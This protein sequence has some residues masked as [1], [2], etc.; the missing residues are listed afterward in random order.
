MPALIM[1]V[2]LSGSGKSERAQ[3]LKNDYKDFDAEIFSLDKLIKTTKADHDLQKNPQKAIRILHK[4]I[5]DHLISGK[6]AIYIVKNFKKGQRIEFL[7]YISKVPG[8]IKVCDI[9]ATPYEECLRRNT[10][11]KQKVPDGVIEAEY[12]KWAPPHYSEGFD[13]INI[14]FP[15]NF[16]YYTIDNFLNEADN[17]DQNNSNHSL[18]LGNHCKKTAKYILAQTED[19]ILFYSALLHDNGKMFVKSELNGKGEDDGNSH[20]FRHENVSSY[21]AMFY[22]MNEFYQGKLHTKNILNDILEI[23]NIIYYHMKPYRSWEQSEK[24]KQ[25]DITLLGKDL[26]NKIMLI[27]EADISAH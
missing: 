16:S 15:F 13:L 5:K 2:G 22:M 17:F 18:T 10:L 19:N 8:I 27:H 25:R 7:N 1:L 9:I 14:V 4:K 3:I 26:Y 6:D 11:S 24:S 12:K 21:D 23:C 20:Y